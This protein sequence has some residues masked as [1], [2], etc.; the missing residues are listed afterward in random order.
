MPKRT[1]IICHISKKSI[2]GLPT[3]GIV[4]A[5]KATD[6]ITGLLVK[7]LGPLGRYAHRDENNLKVDI[8]DD[9]MIYNSNVYI[10]G[11]FKVWFGDLYMDSETQKTL[12]EV[13]AL[14]SKKIY[15]LC[16]MD[17]RF[18]SFIPTDEYLEKVAR[19]K[20]TQGAVEENE[21]HLTF[22]AFVGG[23]QEIITIPDSKRKEMV[24]NTEGSIGYAY[25][26]K[27]G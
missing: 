26:G 3:D 23:K 21:P 8:A 16:E 10:E 18:L 13:S 2:F 6:E 24:K 22:M 4:R 9:K 11:G 20:F 5:T 17:G 15:V 14:T 1:R 25:R 12:K 7:R 19:Y 27:K